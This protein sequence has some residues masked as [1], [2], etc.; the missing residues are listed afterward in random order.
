MVL[1]SSAP[2][3]IAEYNLALPPGVIPW[4]SREQRP[5]S[6]NCFGF[7]GAN[8]H[9]IIDDAY[10]YLADRSIEAAHST[11]LPLLETTNSTEKEGPK[12][13]RKRL[14]VLNAPGNQALTR[15]IE[16]YQHYAASSHTSTQNIAY[17]LTQRW[18]LFKR[19]AFIVA[20]TLTDLRN[21]IRE[22]LK[23]YTRTS[24]LN[25]IT[26]TFTGQGTYWSGIG[27]VLL[28]LFPVFA[29]SAAKSCY[30]LR[31]LGFHYNLLTEL[32]ASDK[33]SSPEYSQPIYSAQQ[34]ALVDLLTD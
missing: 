14:F 34:T 26:W 32:Q 25:G 23:H 30:Y 13:K 28:S 5:A 9:V 33:I 7:G 17:T 16:A 12:S 19:R 31:L 20:D 15:I 11:I 18:S 4:P 21:K 24:K 29:A 6:V 3:S 27:K 10:H 22:G 2:R 8:A 1:S